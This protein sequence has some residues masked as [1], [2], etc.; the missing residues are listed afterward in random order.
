MAKIDKYVKLT[1]IYLSNNNRKKV[2]D[3]DASSL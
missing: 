2:E 1:K 3:N